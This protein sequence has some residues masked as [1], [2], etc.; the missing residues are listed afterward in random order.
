MTRMTSLRSTGSIAVALLLLAACGGS[1]EKSSDTT[2]AP[3]STLSTSTTT[4]STTATSTTTVTTELT[5]SDPVLVNLADFKISIDTTTFKAGVINFHVSNLGDTPH[6]F[7]IA[8]G[9]SYEELPHL[10]NGSIDEDTLGDDL[11]GRTPIVDKVLAPTRD[12]T[13][14]LE[15]GNYVLFCNLVVGPVSHAARGHVLSVTVVD[16]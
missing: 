1:D 11:L 9:N 12:I 13:F 7:G 14:T 15:P 3:D 10:A 6:E 5:N 2:A 16:G 8:R 4:A